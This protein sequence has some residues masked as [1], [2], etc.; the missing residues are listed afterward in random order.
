[1][2]CL[3]VMGMSAMV[4]VYNEEVSVRGGG[5][6][7]ENFDLKLTLTNFLRKICEF[8]KTSCKRQLIIINCHFTRYF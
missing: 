7:P 2:S 8:H 5:E 6:E 1:M 4:S 3:S